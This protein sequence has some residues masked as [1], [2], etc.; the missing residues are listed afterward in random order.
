MEIKKSYKETATVYNIKYSALT[1][2]L[3][4]HSPNPNTT[5]LKKV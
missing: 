3:N 4:P 5:N 1:S 2:M